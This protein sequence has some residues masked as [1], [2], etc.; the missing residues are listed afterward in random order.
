DPEQPKKEKAVSKKEK[1]AENRASAATGPVVSA[2]QQKVLK[3]LSVMK[4]TFPNEYAQAC[5]N[6]GI[7]ERDITVEDAPAIIK[8]MN[9]ILEA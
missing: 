4:G 1:S 9:K 3:N 2:D 8:E 6:A 7:G 5:V